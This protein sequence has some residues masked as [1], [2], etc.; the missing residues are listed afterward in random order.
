MFFKEICVANLFRAVGLNYLI[1]QQTGL[2]D[3][4]A[5]DKTLFPTQKLSSR[6][7]INTDSQSIFSENKKS[8]DK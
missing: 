5:S 3:E 8:F 1:F 4:T 2:Y 7:Q 6:F